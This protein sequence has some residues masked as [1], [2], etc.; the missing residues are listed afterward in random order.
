MFKCPQCEDL[1]SQYSSILDRLALLFCGARAQTWNLVHGRWVLYH[2]KHTPLFR[3][4]VEL[5]RLHLLEW[6]VF[7]P[8]VY[9]GSLLST[10]CSTYLFGSHSDWEDMESHVV[11][12]SF[13]WLLRMLNIF[14][15]LLVIVLYILRTVNFITYYYYQLLPIIINHLSSSSS[16]LLK[17]WYFRFWELFTPDIA[18]P[19][20]LPFL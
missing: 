1:E 15:C 8:V 10:L 9:K 14:I 12:F 13:P 20:F 16:L 2:S 11:Q 3:G 4:F 18:K 17:F 5:S 6:C 7:P 19:I